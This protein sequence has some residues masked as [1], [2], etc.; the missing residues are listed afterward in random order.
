MFLKQ[1]RAEENLS[2]FLARETWIQSDVCTFFC[3]DS[4]SLTSRCF[5]LCLHDKKQ[6]QKGDMHSLHSSQN[7]SMSQI[8]FQ[9][10]PAFSQKLAMLV[11][12]NN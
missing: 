4:G 11:Y 12:Q 2:K 9:G 10:L 7:K 1:T 6:N 8:H 5:A 3:R